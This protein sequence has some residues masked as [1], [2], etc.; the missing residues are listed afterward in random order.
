LNNPDDF[1]QKWKNKFDVVTCSG[2]INNNYMDY[3]LFEEMLLSIRKGG[4]AIFAARF[5]FIGEYWYDEE[6]NLMEKEG[7][8]KLIETESFFKY[9]K[10]EDSVGRFS[11]TPCKVFVY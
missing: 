4:Y 3:R 8:W 7:R 9:D 10:I 5:S 11:K 2:L 1:P 6:I